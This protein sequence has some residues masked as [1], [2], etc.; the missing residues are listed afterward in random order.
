MLFNQMGEECLLKS[1]L[2]METAVNEE[3]IPVFS[4]PVLV[5][6]PL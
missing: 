5:I 2:S 4:E 6:E 3:K 1:S